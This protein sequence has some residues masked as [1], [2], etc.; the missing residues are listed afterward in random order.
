MPT[1]L[2]NVKGGISRLYKF[3]KLP[4]QTYTSL[5]AHIPSTSSKRQVKAPAKK[6][7]TL[8]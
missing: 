4:A 8:N 5:S 1:A 3:M 7:I 6:A 2:N